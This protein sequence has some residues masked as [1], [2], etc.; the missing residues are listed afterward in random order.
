M[1]VAQEFDGSSGSVNSGNSDS[2]KGLSDDA[3]SFSHMDPSHPG[4]PP[5][6]PRGPQYSSMR[7]SFGTPPVPPKVSWQD[8]VDDNNDTASLRNASYRFPVYHDHHPGMLPHHTPHH[9]PR[10]NVTSTPRA[11]DEHGIKIHMDRSD[12]IV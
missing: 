9:A 2:G 1:P 12:T 11:V 4:E 8:Q 6:R 7:G 5:P 3:E 10:Y